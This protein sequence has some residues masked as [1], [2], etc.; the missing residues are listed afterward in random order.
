MSNQTFYFLVILGIGL[1]VGFI[2][3]MK[4]ATSV[5]ALNKKISKALET[6]E[7]KNAQLI[8]ELSLK[9]IALR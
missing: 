3:F 8:E 6:S 7:A 2:Y 5:K 1:V 9:N 4:E